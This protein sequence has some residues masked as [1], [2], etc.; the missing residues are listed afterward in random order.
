MLSCRSGCLSDFKGDGG[1]GNEL[2]GAARGQSRFYL[3]MTIFRLKLK[4]N[5]N[6]RVRLEERR[7]SMGKAKEVSGQSRIIN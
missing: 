2:R 3:M 4:M 1:G 7:P 6:G 5:V